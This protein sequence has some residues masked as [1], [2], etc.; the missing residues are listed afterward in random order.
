MRSEDVE[1]LRDEDETRDLAVAFRDGQATAAGL[2]ANRVEIEAATVVCDD[3]LDPFLPERRGQCNPA[4]RGLA[5]RDPRRGSF[6][7][8]VDGV[9]H[10]VEKRILDLRDDRAV[11]LDLASFDGELDFLAGPWATSRAA[12]SSP[13]QASANGTIRARMTSLSSGSAT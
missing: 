12:R 10:Q 1:K 9:A 2:G 4:T 7:A 5:G 11:D 3:D 8:M 13:S 6:D